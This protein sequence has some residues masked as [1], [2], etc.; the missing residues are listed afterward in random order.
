MLTVN[1]AKFRQGLETI[2]KRE[3]GK[4]K[5]KEL[6]P[7]RNSMGPEWM[8]AGIPRRWNTLF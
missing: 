7:E 6:D 8:N 4:K 2:G 3:E 5:K 1:D